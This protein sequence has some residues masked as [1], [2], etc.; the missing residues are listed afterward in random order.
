[1]REVPCRG[2]AQTTWWHGPA[3]KS[4]SINSHWIAISTHSHRFLITGSHIACGKTKKPCCT[5][6]Q[7]L[8]T[9]QCWHQIPN[10]Y[11]HYKTLSSHL[12]TKMWNSKNQ[13]MRLYQLESPMLLGFF[14]PY[15]RQVH[16][17]TEIKFPSSYTCCVLKM[18][19]KRKWGPNLSI[20]WRRNS[21]MMADISN[22]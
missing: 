12:M 9:R 13:G 2:C 11:H 19:N 22:D 21:I 3:A 5:M 16:E 18:V 6:R 1:M 15:P 8:A 4:R 17:P 7:Y 20:M 10:V 14:M